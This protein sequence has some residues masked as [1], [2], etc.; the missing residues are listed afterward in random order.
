MIGIAGILLSLVL[1]MWLAYRGVSVIVLAPVLAMLA[2]VFNGGV[3][4]LGT[5]TQVFMTAMGGFAVKYF[6]IFLL[7]AI[8]GKLM[9]DSGC[10]RAIAQ[11]F[12]RRLGARHGILAI[13]LACGL[14]EYGGV[15]AFVVAFSVYPLAAALFRELDIPKRLI[16]GTLALGAFTFAMTC[17]PGTAQIHNLIPMPYF[18]TTAFAAP[19]LG[20]LGGLGMMG[21]GVWWLNRRYRQAEAAGEGYGSGHSNE[22]AQFDGPT[23]GF[24]V[25]VL[26][27]V[28]VIGVNFALVEWLIPTWDTAY[29]ATEDFG[30]TD[31]G[32]L[33]GLWAMIVALLVANLSVILIHYRSWD[34]L[35]GS[36]KMAA[37]GSLLPTFNTASEVGYGTTIAS[38]S[39]F[40][41]VKNAVVN[42][43]PGNPLISEMVAINVLAG[44]TGSASGGLSIALAALGDTYNQLA[45]DLNIPRELMH[46]IASMACGGFDTLPHNGAVITLLTICG[47]TH[48]QAYKDIAMVTIGIPFVVTLTSVLVLSAVY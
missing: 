10:A 35:N 29:L 7:G 21:G 39:A 8:F 4:L 32:K 27:I 17:L 36:L 2:C 25:A 41:L 37:N 15:S 44:I 3:P 13:V 40:V 38:L 18:E 1:L 26:P 6:P 20:L 45:A 46:R 33:R 14:L 42:V 34:R 31:I 28:L 23:P 48:R 19:V 43:A 22:P 9:E 24:G 5:Y 11:T 30:N 12:V 16:G 47:L